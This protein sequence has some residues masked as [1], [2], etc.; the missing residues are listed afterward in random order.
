MSQN[1][2]NRTVGGEIID[3][4]RRDL[5]QRQVALKNAMTQYDTLPERKIPLQLFKD[6]FLNWMSGQ[7]K[8]DGT[9]RQNWIAIASGVFNRVTIT[10]PDGSVFA[11]A[12]PL[13]DRNSLKTLS[14]DRSGDNLM[15]MAQM[16]A[17]VLPHLANNILRQ[18][19]NSRYKNIA[20]PTTE[21]FKREWKDFL[22][23]FNEAGASVP[24]QGKP[25]PDTPTIEYEYE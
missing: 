12:P 20:Q 23:L 19:L 1:L 6:N 22:A 2:K 10:N 3:E 14:R 18:S 7:V 15:T 25:D 4:L 17:D 13:C 21:G 5:Q 11:V 8:D 16:R 24:T 9:L